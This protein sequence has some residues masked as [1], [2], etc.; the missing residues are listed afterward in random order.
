FIPI[1]ADSK[2]VGMVIIMMQAEEMVKEIVQA[3][4]GKKGQDIRVLK[5]GEL[6][7][8]AEYFI[9]CSATSSTQIKALSDACDK[10]MKDLG[11]PPHHV[12]G[13]RGGTWVLMDFSAVIVH[14]FNEE[15][16]Q[17][18]DLEHMWQDAEQTDV[19]QWL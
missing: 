19:S 18:Y 9:L 17:F 5:T 11:E 15:A 7:T 3:L 12:E 8:L 10:R 14:I 1:C 2:A 4:D 6:T 13:H 16:R